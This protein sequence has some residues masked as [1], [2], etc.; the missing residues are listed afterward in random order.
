MLQY[1]PFLS[2]L[3]FL[4]LLIQLINILLYEDQILLYLSLRLDRH[5]LKKKKKKIV[6]T[7]STSPPFS[8]P[9]SNVSLVNLNPV[10]KKQNKKK[11]T[12]TRNVIICPGFQARKVIKKSSFTEQKER[13]FITADTA[14]LLNR[15]GVCVPVH[16]FHLVCVSA[17]VCVY[18]CERVC[19]CVSTS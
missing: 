17:C 16:A 4:C 1:A 14:H 6:I 12:H 19:M 5:I 3:S 18:V 13:K 9:E 8:L 7:L 11:H 10:Q 2:N 15:M